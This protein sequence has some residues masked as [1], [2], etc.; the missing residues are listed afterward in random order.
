M[1]EVV[2]R[3][4]PSIL[5]GHIQYEGYSTYWGPQCRTS[6]LIGAIAWAVVNFFL[7]WIP[8]VG[9]LLALIAYIAVIKARYPGGW[10]KAILIAPVAWIAPIIVLYVLA[11]IGFASFEVVGVPG[12]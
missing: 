10:V 4:L 11:A 8:F 9:P 1:R 6:P 2:G 7:S 5:I 12:V 3:S